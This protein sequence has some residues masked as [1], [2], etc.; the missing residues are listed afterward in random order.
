MLALRR[1]YTQS[2]ILEQ[3]R[4]LLQK[5]VW[6]AGMGFFKERTGEGNFSNRGHRVPWRPP[7]F[8]ESMVEKHWDTFKH[9]VLDALLCWGF[10]VVHFQT[11][12]QS[13]EKVADD[14]ENE[15]PY[16]TVVPPELFR[17]LVSTTLTGGTKFVALDVRDRTEIPDT[18]VY[19]TGGFN[20]TVRANSRVWWRKPCP[21]LYS[22]A[23]TGTPS[24]VSAICA[25][26]RR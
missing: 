11:P 24:C 9:D 20:P 25:A 19:A 17:L 23:V 8:V 1:V 6:S 10:C 4:S 13:G 18:V 14:R 12:R 26:A 7:P 16:P 21:T 15:F 3:I 22:C 2:A 5:S